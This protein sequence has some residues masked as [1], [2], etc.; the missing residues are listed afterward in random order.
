MYIDELVWFNDKKLQVVKAQTRNFFF[1][2]KLDFTT[3]KE[4]PSP[5]DIAKVNFFANIYKENKAQIPKEIAPLFIKILEYGALHTIEDKWEEDHVS[6]RAHCK[7]LQ[8]SEKLSNKSLL[9]IYSRNKLCRDN[10]YPIVM[11]IECL[12]EEDWP[13][14]PEEILRLNKELKVSFCDLTTSN[15]WEKYELLSFPQ[16]RLFASHMKD[17]AFKILDLILKREPVLV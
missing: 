14:N 9:K 15:G 6:R 11:F 7:V 1:L 8:D 16:K 2:E 12:R 3:K 5:A 17:L 13:E 4:N 10:I